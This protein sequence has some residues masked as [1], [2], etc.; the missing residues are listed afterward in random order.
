[1][2]N[3]K[4][5][6]LNT[7]GICA[8]C[9]VLAVSCSKDK[10]ADIQA[11]Q[12]P[13]AKQDAEIVLREAGGDFGY[14]NPFRHQNRGPGFFKMELIYDS[15]LEKDEKGLIPWLAKEWTVSEDGQTYTF[16]LVDNA[17]WHDGKPLTA[18]D[19]A[20]TVKY[21]EAYHSYSGIYADRV[22]KNRQYAHYPQARL[23]KS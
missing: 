6:A 8:L 21:F 10:N 16:T 7:L 5:S 14:P 3:K 20:F 13:V 18:E 12:K 23:G 15:L 4:L 19:V 9:A 17:T 11:M 1:M 22:G 2:L